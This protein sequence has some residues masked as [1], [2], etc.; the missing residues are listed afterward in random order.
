MNSK[1]NFTGFFHFI[2]VFFALFVLTVYFIERFNGLLDS[3]WS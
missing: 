3:F 2:V 1:L